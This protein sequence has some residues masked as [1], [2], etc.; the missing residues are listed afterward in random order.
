MRKPQ[1]IDAG[2]Q[3]YALLKSAVVVNVIEADEAFCLR[4]LAAGQCDDFIQSDD[5]GPGW[6]LH[7]GRLIEPPP[8]APPATDPIAEALAAIEVAKVALQRARAR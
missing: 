3:R 1:A 2:K 6:I 4:L 8:S 5:A 7:N